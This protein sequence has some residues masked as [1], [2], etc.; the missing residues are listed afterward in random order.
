LNLCASSRLNTILTEMTC[1][2]RFT[3]IGRLP[4]RLYASPSSSKYHEHCMSLRSA[5]GDGASFCVV[6]EQALI[7]KPSMC[8]VVQPSYLGEQAEHLVSFFDLTS[9]QPVFSRLS[10]EESVALV[11]QSCLLQRP[12]RSIDVPCPLENVSPS[13]QRLGHSWMSLVRQI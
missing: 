8:R 9:S 2:Y 12:C 5:P 11:Q 10:V 1:S 6:R 3:A 13:K 4:A 7:S